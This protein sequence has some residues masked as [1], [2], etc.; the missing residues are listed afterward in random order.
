MI[1]SLPLDGRRP[2][3]SGADP[4]VRQGIAHILIFVKK[5]SALSARPLIGPVR[6][7]A[8]GRNLPLRQFRSHRRRDNRAEKLD[9]AQDG[10]LRLGADLHLDEGALVAE[11]LVLG[12]DF[13]DRLA[14]RPDHQMTAG[15]TALIEYR[16]R[17][18]RPAALA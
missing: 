7:P 5:V 2:R 14:G 13:G 11:D 16:P 18:R 12:K 15:A 1:L 6:R 10:G 3:T 9:R 4:G 17:E 8:S